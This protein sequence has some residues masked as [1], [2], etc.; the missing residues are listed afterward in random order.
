MVFRGLTPE[1]KL[2]GYQVAVL[3][4]DYVSRP[5]AHFQLNAPVLA[6]GRVLGPTCRPVRA[7]VG[8][9]LR[10]SDVEIVSARSGPDGRFVLR[11]D[12]RT[13][14]FQAAILHGGPVEF[15]LVA[16]G[17][18]GFSFQRF[19]RLPKDARWT[20]HGKPAPLTL[21]LSKGSSPS[22]C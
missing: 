9:S 3:G 19:R 2:A 7:R 15:T 20:W 5:D 17:R 11:V 21:K 12:P 4:L 18:G 10:G 16:E 1:G 8:A 22:A 6:T 14:P 13:A